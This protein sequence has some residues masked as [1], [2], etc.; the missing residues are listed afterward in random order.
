M[1]RDCKQITD[2]DRDSLIAVC[3]E[4]S[5]YLD[6]TRRVRTSGMVVASPSGYPIQNPYISIAKGALAA[7]CR[8]WAELGLTPSS[9]SRVRVEGSGPGPEG[10][11]FSEFD[12]P[13][14]LPEGQRPH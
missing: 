12:N 5:R 10:D 8:L 6:A 14:T 7:C 13:P 11:A 3:L 1:L 2:A 9:R 4:W